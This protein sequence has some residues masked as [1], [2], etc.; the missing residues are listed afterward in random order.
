MPD[1]QGVF[2]ELSVIWFSC[3]DCAC[4]G[5]CD[6]LPMYPGKESLWSGAHPCQACLP[7]VSRQEPL[8]VGIRSVG[9]IGGKTCTVSKLDGEYSLWFLQVLGYLGDKRGKG[10]N[11]CYLF[12]YFF[13]EKS[14][15]NPCSCSPCSERNK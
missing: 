1:W 2:S 15:K 12:F 6:Y 5:V 11:I 9:E 14:L 3:W 4:S 13:W 7:D 10:S 8:F